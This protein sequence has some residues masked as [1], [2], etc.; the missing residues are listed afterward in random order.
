M[1]EIDTIRNN[2]RKAAA[3]QPGEMQPVIRLLDKQ[4]RNF[5]RGSP[6][7]KAALRQVIRAS[8]KRIEARGDGR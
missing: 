7:D 2:L 5:E 6:D 8:L 3:R 1:S 4:L